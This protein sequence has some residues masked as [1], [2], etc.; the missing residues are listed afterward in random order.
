MILLVVLAGGVWI[1]LASFNV[2][3]YIPFLTKKIGEAIQREVSIQNGQLKFSFTEGVNLRLHQIAISDDPQFARGSFLAVNEIACGVDI[4]ALMT[5]RKIVITKILVQ[6]PVIAVTRRQDG[7]MNIPQPVREQAPPLSE[8][9]SPR[10]PSAQNEQPQMA[11]PDLLVR[12]VEIQDGS[13]RY[14]NEAYPEPLVLKVDNIDLIVDQL[15]LD[16]PFHFM[17][18]AAMLSNAQNIKGEGVAQL[19]INEQQASFPSIQVK[20]D[21]S[22]IDLAA[23]NALNAQVKQL[24]LKGLKGDLT[25]QVNPMVVGAKGLATLNVSGMLESGLVQTT[26]LPQALT[27]IRAVFSA[28]ESDVEL[29]GFDAY[30][31][32]GHVSGKIALMDYLKDQ[33][34]LLETEILGLKLQDVLAVQKTQAQVEGQVQAKIKAQGQGLS[35]DI[36]SRIS[37]QAEWALTDGRIVDFN[38]LKAVLSKLTVIPAL[39]DQLTARLPQKW[40]ERLSVKDTVLKEVQGFVEIKEG[41]IMIN[42]A[43]LQSDDF[44]LEA[45][46]EVGLDLSVALNATLLIDAELSQSM[47]ES[48]EE[49]QALMDEKNQITIPVNINGKYPHIV[50]MPDIGYLGQKIGVQFGVKE[51]Q[52]VLEKNPEVKGIL[53][54]LLGTDQQ[55][56][57]QNDD[58]SSQQPPQEPAAGQGSNEPGV[59]EELINDLLEK[60]FN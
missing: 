11:L 1:F 38:L 20:T 44:G 53:N 58:P 35:S 15:S 14:T 47:V 13:I 8:T 31:G 24:G 34:F 4:N 37:G 49:L 56:V 17:I 10:Q 52:K 59:E 18:Q 41:K 54:I 30:L 46:G 21:L 50:P 9:Q 36:L 42:D 19:N 45:Q 27:Q 5:K 28:T 33:K 32:S 7:S 51:L 12:Q 16:R 22:F 23:L 43:G 55:P 39:M 25:V 26:L 48:V 60:V 40:Q 29:K 57:E 3:R 2:N 6:N